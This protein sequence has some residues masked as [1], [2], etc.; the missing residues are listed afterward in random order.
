MR[1]V[2]HP[3]AKLQLRGGLDLRVHAAHGACDLDQTFCP[4]RVTSDERC[5]LRPRT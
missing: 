1:D 4:A 5:N 2:R 3:C